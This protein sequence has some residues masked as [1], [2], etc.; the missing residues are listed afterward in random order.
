MFMA[1]RKD[2]NGRYG[3]D[4]RRAFGQLLVLWER[5]KMI[6]CPRIHKETVDEGDME[7]FMGQVV[8]AV[9]QVPESY[10]CTTGIPG[11]GLL[12]RTGANTLKSYNNHKFE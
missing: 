9:V 2:Q 11:Y 1:D 10:A 4:H 8:V 6:E 3:T 7:F 12:R 5:S